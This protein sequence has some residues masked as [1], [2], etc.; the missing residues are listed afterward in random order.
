MGLECCRPGLF[1]QTD[2]EEDC[3]DIITEPYT[4]KDM[5]GVSQDVVITSKGSKSYKIIGP[6]ACTR[7]RANSGA[8]KTS[9]H[10]AEVT[11]EEKF[12]LC[13]QRRGIE[14]NTE[15]LIVSILNPFIYNGDFGQA[16]SVGGGIRRILQKKV[17]CDECLKL[18][19][20]YITTC[21]C[22]GVP[23]NQQTFDC[24]T[25]CEL[26]PGGRNP[27]GTPISDFCSSGSPIY[28]PDKSHNID[29]T[30][31]VIVAGDDQENVA[32]GKNQQWFVDDVLEL[33]FSLC[34]AE[35]A[36]I[37][38]NDP[39]KEQ[40]IINFYKEKIMVVSNVDKNANSFFGDK[41][42]TAENYPYTMPTPWPFEVQQGSRVSLTYIKICDYKIKCFS[43]N[44]AHIAAKINQK[45]GTVVQA[46]PLNTNFWFGYRQNYS[47]CEESQ[48]RPPYI[49]G[50]YL[51][52]GGG[53]VSVENYNVKIKLTGTAQ[54]FYC[55]SSQLVTDA[56]GGFSVG[57]LGGSNN[58]CISLNSVSPPEMQSGIKFDMI[59]VAQDEYKEN[60]CVPPGDGGNPAG[61]L[62]EVV[63]IPVMNGYP[64]FDIYVFDENETPILV[65]KGYLTLCSPPVRPNRDE[66]IYEL[67]DYEWMTCDQ[68]T[69]CESIICD[70]NFGGGPDF[71]LGG[72][73]C[74]VGDELKHIIKMELLKIN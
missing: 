53:S 71:L 39:S 57:I 24:C 18:L 58:Y 65:K 46:T 14:V 8:E 25:Q 67:G 74:N 27:N 61:E 5:F 6:D 11:T 59:F 50:D 17:I 20:G 43:G 9:Y 36:G 62:T 15:S 2:P 30:Y 10:L 16:T 28:D 45:I 37:D 68:E 69:E 40:E 42:L 4:Y 60:I 49:M 51:E 64:Q 13:I 7:V 55:C 34:S 72:Q 35:A 33:T 26:K 22:E 1:A 54:R 23:C 3:E 41:L 19:N 63:K 31:S 32:Y 29:T 56:G 47:G 70:C 52:I 48:R 12:G 44:S 38:V 66:N 73:P 21:A